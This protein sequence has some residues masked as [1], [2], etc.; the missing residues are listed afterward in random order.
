MSWLSEFGSLIIAQLLLIGSGIGTHFG[1]T[2]RFTYVPQPAPTVSELRQLAPTTAATIPS[3][4][5]ENAAYQQAAI[6]RSLS[7]H[8]FTPST[9]P[10]ETLVNIFCTYRTNDTI[11][12][13]TGSG[14]FIDPTGIIL[15]NAHVA[16][17]LLLE[18]VNEQGETDCVVRHGNPATPTYEAQLLYISPLWVYHHAD[19]ISQVEPK[20][21][22]ERDYALLYL[23][24]RLDGA[25]LPA[26]VPY[27]SVDSTLR[28][29][30]TVGD[31]VTIAGYP[32]AD[33]DILLQEET[34][35]LATAKTTLYDLFTFGTNYGDIYFLEGSTIG[36]QGISGGPVLDENA[37]AVAL[38]VTRGNDA[39]QGAGSL[40][41]ITLSYVDR[42]IEEETGF[43]L[44]QTISGNTVYK[45]QVFTETLVPF[46]AGLL[47]QQ[48]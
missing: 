26:E 24:E 38:I 28:D 10:A 42:T 6:A 46:L 14:F 39:V 15:T 7:T 5:L 48:L 22:G 43:G 11:R 32:T 16:Q 1:G 18:T 34:I 47:E 9:D 2:D 29:I 36:Q 21:T 27:L 8:Q 40:N 37:N 20:G 31:T 12:Y 41:A 35:P 17:F 33:P 30:R 13:T 45:A 4:L 25:P 44:A 19:L 23:T 3:I